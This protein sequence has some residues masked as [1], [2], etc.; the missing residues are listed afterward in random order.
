M[1][2]SLPVRIGFNWTKCGFIA[3]VGIECFFDAFC[4]DPQTS[5][6]AQWKVTTDKSRVDMDMVAGEESGSEVESGWSGV[7]DNSFTDSEC[8][9]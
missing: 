6:R 2:D 1:P 8:T 4:F 3:S 9:T 5:S 7:S